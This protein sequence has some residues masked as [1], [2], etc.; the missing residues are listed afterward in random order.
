MIRNIV[1]GFS[2]ACLLCAVVL[3]CGRNDAGVAVERI[4]IAA[5][6]YLRSDSAG[7]DSIEADFRPAMAPLASMAGV[8]V[9]SAMMVYARSR[10]QEVF[11][12]DVSRASALGDPSSP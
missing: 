3:S 6:R 1:C 2:L 7:R 11:A 10:A 5:M 9:D 4:D 12:P 8:P